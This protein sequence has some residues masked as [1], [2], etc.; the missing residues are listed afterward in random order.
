MRLISTPIPNT[1]QTITSHSSFRVTMDCYEHQ[2]PFDNHKAATDAIAMEFL[3]RISR[4]DQNIKLG[5]LMTNNEKPSLWSG[6]WGRTKEVA[7]TYTGTFIVVMILNQLV[8]FGFC[9]NPVCLIAAM[10]HVGC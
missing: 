2:F 1:V 5:L 6:L 8:F 4:H 7:A 3:G 9:L 10:P